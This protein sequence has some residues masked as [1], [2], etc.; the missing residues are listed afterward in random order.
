MLSASSPKTDPLNFEGDKPRLVWSL[1]ASCASKALFLP[2]VQRPSAPKS[3]CS[4]LWHH[5]GN[6]SLGFQRVRWCKWRDPLGKQKRLS[7]CLWVHR[8]TKTKN[9]NCQCMLYMWSILL[10]VAISGSILH[11]WGVRELCKEPRVL[12]YRAIG[13]EY[14]YIK[15]TLTNTDS[16]KGRQPSPQRQQHIHLDILYIHTL[17][18]L[19]FRF[20]DFMLFVDSWVLSWFIGHICQLGCRETYLGHV[21]FP[22][23][24]AIVLGILHEGHFEVQE[25]PILIHSHLKLPPNVLDI[26]ANT[27]T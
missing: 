14:F 3:P 16:T 13:T 22:H 6:G 11:E 23:A 27:I 15:R 9:D 1:E 5:K 21:Q 2:R 18:F 19:S 20:L 4:N 12:Y 8:H 17:V 10:Q 25:C 7:H 24:S 26:L